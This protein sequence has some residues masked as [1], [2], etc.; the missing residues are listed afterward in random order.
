MSELNELLQQLE[1]IGEGAPVPVEPMSKRR[2]GFPSATD[3]KSKPDTTSQG[4]PFQEKLGANDPC[5]CGSGK[6]FRSCHMKVKG[7]WQRGNDYTRSDEV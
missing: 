1:E 3:V 2:K 4:E 5:P 7:G 6:K